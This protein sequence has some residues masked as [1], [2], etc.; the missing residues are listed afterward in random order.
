MN[1]KNKNEDFY[2]KWYG[3]LSQVY[4]GQ[5]NKKQFEKYVYELY[6]FMSTIACIHVDTQIK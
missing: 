6:L 4:C 3:K 1:N 5:Y 2:E